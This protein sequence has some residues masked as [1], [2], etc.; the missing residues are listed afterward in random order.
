MPEEIDMPDDDENEDRSESTEDG[1]VVFVGP[2]QFIE[3]QKQAHDKM[4]AQADL[5]RSS[6]EGLIDELTSE[7]TFTLYTMF[8]HLVQSN[9]A[10]MLH[11]MSGQLAASMRLKHHACM[12]CGSAGHE[13]V[14]H[15]M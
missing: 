6:V 3:A 15:G 1:T 2:Q 11:Y 5:L 8:Q 9:D 13:T 12:K 4:L 14:M 10:G 7:Q